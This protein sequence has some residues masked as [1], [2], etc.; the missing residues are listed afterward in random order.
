MATNPI[1]ASLYS[2]I[3]YRPNQRPIMPPV[4]D[5]IVTKKLIDYFEEVI[6]AVCFCPMTLT[7]DCAVIC[8]F[9]QSK[10]VFEKFYSNNVDPLL[11]AEYWKFK[12][13]PQPLF[14]AINGGALMHAFWRLMNGEGFRTLQGIVFIGDAPGFTN[15]VGNGLLFKDCTGPLH[16]E[17]THS[18]QWLTIC[19]LKRCCGKGVIE[20]GYDFVNQIG[21]IYKKVPTIQIFTWPSQG[22]TQEKWPGEIAFGS[23]KAKAEEKKSLWDLMV[24]GFATHDSKGK[25]LN[26]IEDPVANLYTSS[27]RCPANVTLAIQFH[28]LKSTFIA[29]W[30]AARSVKYQKRWDARAQKEGLPQRDEGKLN[31]YHDKKY[32]AVVTE[33]QLRKGKELIEKNTFKFVVDVGDDY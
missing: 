27:Y 15:I 2:A 19:E 9:L 6:D 25:S 12:K 16:G 18:L 32:H 11:E 4:D 13:D 33:G 3:A 5:D 24:D 8:A 1:P 20:G 21:E 31:W 29:K 10:K 30:W 22:D 7:R 23:L 28:D 14:G 17:F 26:V